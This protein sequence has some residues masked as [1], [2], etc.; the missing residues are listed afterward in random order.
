MMILLITIPPDHN[1]VL[2][3]AIGCDVDSD[4]RISCKMTEQQTCPVYCCNDG[5][6]C[7]ERQG[8]VEPW[9]SKL[10]DSIQPGISKLFVY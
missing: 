5:D 2:I 7:Y 4:S 3:L 10:I 8:T 1:S 6:D 9:D